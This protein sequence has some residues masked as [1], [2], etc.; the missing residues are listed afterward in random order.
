MN[1]RSFALLLWHVKRAIYLI[2]LW[3]IIAIILSCGAI[4]CY[5]FSLQQYQMELSSL[6][7]QVEIA[8]QEEKRMAGRYQTESER[9]QLAADAVFNQLLTLDR[10][11]NLLKDIN[12]QANVQQLS[13]KEGNYQFRKVS[14]SEPDQIRHVSQYEMTLPI[15]G[16]YK[17]LRNFISRILHD[18]PILSISTIKLRRESIAIPEI[19]ADLVLV[20]FVKES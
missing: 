1:N 15:K 3:G 20:V 17:K 11:P 13:L 2:G 18:T 8:A 10:L 16:D 7:D 19:E 14:G 5:W 6:R 9:T 12:H 4:Y